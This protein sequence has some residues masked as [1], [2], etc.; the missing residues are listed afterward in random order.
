MRA[1]P[2]H[3]LVP[4]KLPPRRH[5]RTSALARQVS[6]HRIDVVPVTPRSTLAPA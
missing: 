5:V 2:N 1:Q 6:G 4:T 3:S